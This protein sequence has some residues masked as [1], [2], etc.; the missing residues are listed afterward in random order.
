MGTCKNLLLNIFFLVPQMTWNFYSIFLTCVGRFVGI[1][2][3][4]HRYLGFKKLGPNDNWELLGI[5]WIEF[6]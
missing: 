2:E 6:K 3:F 1:F 4:I 5:L